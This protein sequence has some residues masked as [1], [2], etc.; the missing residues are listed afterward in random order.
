VCEKLFKNSKPFGKNFQKTVG[1]IFFDS[2]CV[3]SFIMQMTNRNCRH[4]R[5]KNEITVTKPKV[6]NIW[7]TT[8]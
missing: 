7:H 4:E 1:G 2:H 8:S 5:K 6:N 3:S